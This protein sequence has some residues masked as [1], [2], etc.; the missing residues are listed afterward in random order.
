MEVPLERDANCKQEPG[1]FKPLIDR[2][3]CEAKA[4]CV[5]VCPYDVF[6]VEV[7]PKTQRAGLSLKGKLKGLAHGWRQALTPNAEACHAC[8]LC[9]AACPEKAITLTLV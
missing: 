3:S 5:K 2:N 4:E 1:A 7:L 9:V 6:V 8:G